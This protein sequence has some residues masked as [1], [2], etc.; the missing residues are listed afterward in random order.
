VPYTIG[1]ALLVLSKGVKI[2]SD[3]GN[4]SLAICEAYC[5]S[6][7]QLQHYWLDHKKFKLAKNYK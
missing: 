6:T 4:Q 5:A 1:S 7:T 3:A 2:A